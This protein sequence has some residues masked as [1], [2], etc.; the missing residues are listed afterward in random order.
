ML[1]WYNQQGNNYLL[2]GAGFHS[3]DLSKH[4]QYLPK[5]AAVLNLFHGASKS[6]NL[7]NVTTLWWRMVQL[8]AIILLYNTR[9]KGKK[10]QHNFDTAKF[11]YILLDT[12]VQCH[13]VI[14]FTLLTL[15]SWDD[16][17]QCTKHIS[18]TQNVDIF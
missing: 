3:N 11:D 6:Y 5:M 8:N 4:W 12:S 1:I 15:I 17:I 16:N 7:I 10:K 9:K 14:T 18:V 13:E 2:E